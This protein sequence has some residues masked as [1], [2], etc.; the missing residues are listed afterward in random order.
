EGVDLSSARQRRP[1]VLLGETSGTDDRGRKAP[2]S[3]GGAA[4]DRQPSLAARRPVRRTVLGDGGQRLVA[5]EHR[6]FVARFVAWAK[7]FPWSAINSTRCALRSSFARSSRAW[8][9]R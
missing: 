9:I 5:G 7:G 8:W 4:L 1:L 2:V 3:A 6:T